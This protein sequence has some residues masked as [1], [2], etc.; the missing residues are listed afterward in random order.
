MQHPIL[1]P[2]CRSLRWSAWLAA[3]GLGVGC[4]G[5]QTSSSTNW[6]RCE[7]DADCAVVAHAVCRSD[8]ICVDAEGRRIPAS[9]ASAGASGAGGRGDAGVARDSTGVSGRSQSD[10]GA[11]SSGGAAVGAA[12]ADNDSS[13]NGGQPPA[14]GGSSADG[15]STGGAGASAPVG[16]A[17]GADTSTGGTTR[18][19]GGASVSTSGAGGVGGATPSAAGSGNADPCPAG[20]PAADAP[21]VPDGLVCDYAGSSVGIVA[22]CEG[23][24]WV[25]ETPQ[26]DSYVC[27]SALPV[28]GSACPEP[29]APTFSALVCL[30][31]CSGTSCVSGGVPDC[32]A[33]QA[34]CVEDAQSGAWQWV[35][36]TSNVQCD[37]V[38]CD[39]ANA[40]GAAA[41]SAP[42]L[43][44]S[45]ETP[46]DC[47]VGRHYF[48]CCG[49]ERYVG[50][51]LSER[52]S[53]DAYELLCESHPACPCPASSEVEDGTPFNKGAVVADCVG[54][55]CKAVCTA[56][57][58]NFTSDCSASDECLQGTTCL[59]INPLSGSNLCRQPDG[60]CGGC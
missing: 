51:N 29:P 1:R 56:E 60:T 17:G 12:G 27:P 14:T 31:D 36:R 22:T 30:F 55:V 32:G 19:A 6:L 38:A 42:E 50:Y 52:D 10:A 4:R 21:C 24:G 33:T 28:E 49:S 18:G 59:W 34:D 45:C 40:A 5:A 20:P 39:D 16:G 44:K 25:L 11:P 53:F 43:D 54:G 57:G 35:Y 48:N 7:T 13:Q 23:G 2:G 3:L 9:A 47:F 8:S 41:W 15:G 26:D 58:C 46:S 37:E